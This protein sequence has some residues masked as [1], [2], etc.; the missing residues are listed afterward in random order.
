[1]GKSGKQVGGNGNKRGS[2]R[3]A[4]DGTEGGKNREGKRTSLPSQ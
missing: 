4:G 2:V 1:M 3:K